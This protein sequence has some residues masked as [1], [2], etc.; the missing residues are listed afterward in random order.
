MLPENAMVAARLAVESMYSAVCTVTETV[1]SVNENFVTGLV[2]SVTI[3]NQPCRVA[4][5]SKVNATDNGNGNVISQ[6]IELFIAPECVIHPGAHITV[7]QN[8]ITKEYQS[9]GISAVYQTH[10]EIMLEAVGDYA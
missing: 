2:D 10:Q 6:Q 5:K 8:G 9:S 7:T 1:K 3:E 4:I